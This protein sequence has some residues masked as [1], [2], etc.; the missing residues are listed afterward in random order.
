ML[1]PYRQE[2]FVKSLCDRIPC[3]I[4]LNHLGDH[5]DKIPV[6]TLLYLYRARNK[7]T[8]LSVPTHAQLQCH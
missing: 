4:K 7:A 8:Q 5:N 1:L 2:A 6:F 3:A